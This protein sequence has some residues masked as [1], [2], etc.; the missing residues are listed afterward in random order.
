MNSDLKALVSSVEDL[1][2]SLREITA[3]IHAQTDTKNEAI[4]KSEKLEFE[5]QNLV[6]TIEEE[7]NNLEKQVLSMVSAATKSKMAITQKLEETK[8]K[9]DKIK[10]AIL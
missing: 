6:K 7:R 8:N 3:V 5:H 4:L 9:I 1:E 2:L 10:N